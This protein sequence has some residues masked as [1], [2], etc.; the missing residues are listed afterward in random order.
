MTTRSGQGQTS[1]RRSSASAASRRLRR[2]LSTTPEAPSTV[3]PFHG[4][5]HK[6]LMLCDKGPSYTDW[7]SGPTS[8]SE[9]SSISVD[10]VLAAFATSRDS[11]PHEAMPSEKT[12]QPNAP[13]PQ[14]GPEPPVGQ[15]AAK[16]QPL[17]RQSKRQWLREQ[18]FPDE[19]T[20]PLDAEIVASMPRRLTGTLPENDDELY[21][22][23]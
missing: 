18:F 12:P 1:R 19:P 11:A 20:F 15:D 10:D 9:A 6:D 4:V 23:E 16:R 13:K 5:D 14:K 22:D 17:P 21:E 3:C 8:S 2:K 7:E